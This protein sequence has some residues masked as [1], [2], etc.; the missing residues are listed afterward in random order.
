MRTRPSGIR[1]YVQSAVSPDAVADANAATIK[2]NQ[3]A[4]EIAAACLLKCRIII[5]L[6]FCLAVDVC[7][8]HTAAAIRMTQSKNHMT[9]ANKVDDIWAVLYYILAAHCANNDFKC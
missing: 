6:E 8:T 9:I 1:P 4:R 2:S 5:C 3:Y 7:S